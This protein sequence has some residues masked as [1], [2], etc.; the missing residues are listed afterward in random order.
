MLIS[1]FILKQVKNARVKSC[2]SQSELADLMN[3]STSAYNKL[4]KG[5]PKL[6]IDRIYQLSSILKLSIWDLL[7][8]N[9]NLDL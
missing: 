3:M 6:D 1:K 9:R 5:D 7:P 4:E 8:R 2:I